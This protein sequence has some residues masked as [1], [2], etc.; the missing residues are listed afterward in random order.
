MQY[1]L[2]PNTGKLL[3]VDFGGDWKTREKCVQNKIVNTLK[4]K[5]L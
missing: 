4:P 2:V 5:L 1:D 3:I